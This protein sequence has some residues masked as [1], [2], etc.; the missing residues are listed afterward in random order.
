[1]ARL[2][3]LLVEARERYAQVDKSDWG[4]AVAAVTENLHTN[5]RNFALDESKRIAALVGRGGGKTTGVRAMLFIDLLTIP[6]A[7]LLYIASTREQA[8]ELMWGPMKQLFEEH[9]VVATWNE[10]KLK[11]AVKKNGAQLILAGADNKK[12]IERFRGLPHHRVVI[13]EAASYSVRLLQHLIYRIIGPRLG[14]YNGVLVLIGTPGHILSTESP[15]YEVTRV[16]SEI[17][18]SHR[19]RF[20]YPLVEGESLDDYW[21]THTWTLEDGANEGIEAMVN[22]W[23][24]ALVEKKRNGWSDSHPVWRREY[25]GQWCAD[26]T[27]NV[28]RYRIHDENGQLW[29]QWTPAKFDR[30]VACLPTEHEF[31]ERLPQ[32]QRQREW[33]YVVGLD[34]GHSDPFSCQVFAYSPTDRC[35]WHVYEFEQTKMFARSIAELFLGPEADHENPAGLFGVIGW[36]TAIVAD[37]AGLGGMVLE[38]LRR[39]YGIAIQP[40]VKKNKFDNIELFNGD[41]IDG[42]IFIMK[43]SKLEEQLLSLQWAVDDFGILKENKSQANH[44]TDAAI[45]ARRYALHMFGDEAPTPPPPPTPESRAA[46][47]DRQALA[48]EVA[49][50][51][52]TANEFENYISASDDFTHM[53]R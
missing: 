51:R 25:L 18:I 10:S 45:Y 40:A 16:G 19:E 21:S 4:A 34:L 29:N 49:A 22:L 38:D 15:F 27:E 36:P 1:M 32:H 13:D 24:A 53:F 12:T 30:G 37:T 17:A 2:D 23:E 48:D 39:I 47:V 14:D 44:S 35:L 31:A 5:Q 41:L 50:A 20:D 42:R 43:G 3:R 26:D 11:L 46:A 6:G 9:G 8:E 28:F 7:R 33:H 52:T